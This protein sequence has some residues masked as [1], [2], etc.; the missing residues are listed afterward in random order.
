MLTREQKASYV[1]YLHAVVLKP[2]IPVV[3]CLAWKILEYFAKILHLLPN[4]LIRGYEVMKKYKNTA[5]C[6]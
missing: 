6:P 1:G 3:F 2:R 4:S 5:Q